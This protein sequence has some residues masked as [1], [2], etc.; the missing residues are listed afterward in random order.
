MYLLAFPLSF[1]LMLLIICL[2][3]DAGALLLGISSQFTFEL[4]A[5]GPLAVNR[6]WPLL[7]LGIV[8][9][10]IDASR[11]RPLVGY[12]ATNQIVRFVAIIS[13]AIVILLL[14]AKFS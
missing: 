4:I 12:I 13:I 11:D 10:G 6:L 2:A 7:L 9:F 5:S 3:L 14:M 8:P 1:W